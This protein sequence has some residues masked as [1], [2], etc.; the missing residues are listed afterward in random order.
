MIESQIYQPLSEKEKLSPHFHSVSKGDKI[1]KRL[2][3]GRNDT[4]PLIIGGYCQTHK[5]EICHCGWEWHWH[6]G[7]YHKP[8]HPNLSP[9]VKYQSKK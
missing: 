1:V 4:Y 8:V 7:K 3:K 6:Y 5:V 9:A 2:Y